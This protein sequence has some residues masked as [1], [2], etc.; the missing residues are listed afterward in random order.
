MYYFKKYIFYFFFYSHPSELNEI[1]SFD[2]KNFFSDFL[3]GKIGGCLTFG[4][5]WQFRTSLGVITVTYH[6]RYIFSLTLSCQE[7]D[8]T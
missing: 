2:K 8:T 4:L 7:F 6:Y 3:I 5:T 1:L